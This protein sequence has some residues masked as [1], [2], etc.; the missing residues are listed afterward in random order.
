MLHNFLIN[1]I[2]HFFIKNNFFFTNTICFK[3]SNIF[4]LNSNIITI[5]LFEK[6]TLEYMIKFL[7]FK[8]TKPSYILLSFYLQNTILIFLV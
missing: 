2:F 5:N 8:L 1:P 6:Y 7:V 4:L 3:T